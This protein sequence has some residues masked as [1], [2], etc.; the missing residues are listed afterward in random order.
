MTARYPEED[1]GPVVFQSQH[2][3]WSKIAIIPNGST[4]GD[5]HGVFLS[6]LPTESE[7]F[8]IFSGSGVRLD[9]EDVKQFAA[10]VLEAAGV[11]VPEELR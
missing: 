8:D 11:A 4:P 6:V 10:I 9:K 7:D 2:E 5:E 3:D 1:R